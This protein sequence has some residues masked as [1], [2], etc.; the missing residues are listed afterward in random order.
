[1][2]RRPRGSPT[3]AWHIT[4]TLHC[5]TTRGTKSCATRG[6]NPTRLYRKVCAT[7]GNIPSPKPLLTLA[8][9]LPHPHPS[10]GLPGAGR[11][12]RV[13]TEIHAFHVPRVVEAWRTA[14]Q[15]LCHAWQ[16]HQPPTR[17]NFYAGR[18]ITCHTWYGAQRAIRKP[19][20]TRGDIPSPQPQQTLL[21]SNPSP[22]P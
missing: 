8:S 10:Q 17:P 4:L 19:C 5:V 3:H 7:H 1:M 16:R 6:G 21:T 22:H 9:T 15:T 11:V 18:R 14:G 20:A 2:Q 12:P 13:G